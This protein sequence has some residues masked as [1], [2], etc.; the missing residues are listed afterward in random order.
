MTRKPPASR[1]SPSAGQHAMSAPPKAPLAPEAL[2]VPPD[3]RA[4]ES[5]IHRRRQ[6]LRETERR[7]TAGRMTLTDF[8]SGHEFFGL[9]RADGDWILREW[10]PAATAIELVGSCNNW[11]P[12]PRYRFQQDTSNGNWTL[13]LPADAL[14]HGDLYKLAVSWNGGSGERIPAWTR[15]AVQDDVTKV[16]SAQVWVPAEPYLWRHPDFRRPAEAPRIYEAHVGMAQEEPRVGTYR[17]FEE[18]TLP[19]IVDAGY[20]TIQLMAIQEHP[21]YGSFGYHVSS[22]FAASSRFGTPED[23]K[24]LVDAAHGAGVAVIMDIVHS[25]AVKNEVEGLSRYDGTYD[26]F[27][28]AGPRGDHIAWDSRCFNYGRTEVLHFLLSNCRFWLDEYRFD[29]FR[30]DGVTSLLY[31]DH[32]LGKRFTSYDDYYGPNVDDDACVYLCLANQV[33]HGV[34]PDAMTVAEDMSGMPGL[35]VPADQ[36]GMGFDYRLA[37]GVPD[38]W[39]KLIKE[40]P[41]EHWHMGELYHELTNRRADEK[42]INY[43]ESHDQALVGDK[44]IIFRLID[45][46]MYWHMNIYEG[47]LGVDR[48]IALH[49]LIRLLTLGTAGHGYLNFMGNEFGHPEW[50]DF[51]RQG[52]NWSYQHARRQWHLRDDT[53][54]RYRFLA[55]FDR[56][57]MALALRSHLLDTPGPRFL[58]EHLTHQILG[59]ERAGLIFLFNFN[60]TQSF[61]DYAFPATAREYRLTLDSDSPGYGG[62]S[63]VTPHQ[64]YFTQPALNPDDHSHRTGMAYLPSRAAIV[65]EPC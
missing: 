40:V 15:R 62:H 65:L 34:R 22:F 11:T 61:P 32:G 43:A 31:F 14:K 54:L 2:H 13:R 35:C 42:T 36:G 6:R 21:Y 12:S 41:D 44:T 64:K 30:F 60:P 10:A 50:I 38:Y 33:I 28:H 25:H 59:F 48:G 7:L 47:D 9:H 46:A 57:M 45:A 4:Y 20:N 3:L 52:N 63:R 29:G 8:A 17:E 58:F 23:L 49:K 56:D 16:F 51:P 5:V 24:R 27:F 37:M 18:K 53:N 26:Q 19:R 39:I 55:E 1:P